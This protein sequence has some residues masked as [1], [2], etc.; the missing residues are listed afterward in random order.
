MRSRTDGCLGHHVPG[1]GVDPRR[2][3][4]LRLDPD[5]RLMR[6]RADTA[7]EDNRDATELHDQQHEGKRRLRPRPVRRR[8]RARWA[9][10][11]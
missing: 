1:A 4:L 3:S 2:G 5:G 9:V 6:I 10:P 8:T 7:D 11:S